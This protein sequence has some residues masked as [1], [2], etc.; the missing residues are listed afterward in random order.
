MSSTS[1]SATTMMPSD[2][3]MEEWLDDKKVLFNSDED[4]RDAEIGLK[5][6]MFDEVL[7][8]MKEYLHPYPDPD[9][10]GKAMW[11]R[12]GTIAPPSL[13][14]STVTWVLPSG[15]TQ[16]RV[17]SLRTSVRRKPI[18]WAMSWEKGMHSS[19]SSVA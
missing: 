19:V 2:S 18:F 3:D 16:G 11:T 5:F 7:T 8:S 9:V 6:D 15:R 13:R 12:T 1:L 17:P 4:G 14:Y 10:E